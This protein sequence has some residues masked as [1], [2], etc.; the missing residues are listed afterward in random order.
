MLDGEIEYK[1]GSFEKAFEM[2]QLAVERN[3]S[4]VDSEP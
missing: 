3:G 4:R 2:L 1:R